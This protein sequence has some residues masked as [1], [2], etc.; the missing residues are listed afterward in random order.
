MDTQDNNFIMLPTVDF[1]F[2]E[3]MQ[4]PKVR[5]GFIAALLNMKPESIRKTILLPTILRRE[6]ENDK[7]GILD[8]RIQLEDGTQMDMEMQVRY[9]EYWD[10]RTLFY[11]SKMFTE[12][13]NAGDDYDALKKCIHISV[14][15]FNHYKDDRCYRTV[16]L[17]D[18]KTG[19]LYSDKIELQILELQKLAKDA[20][21]DEDII[22]WI[23]FFAGKSR[24]EFEK[25]AKNDEYLD[26][27][28]NELLKLSADERKRLEYNAREKALLDHNSFMSSAR[29]Q[30]LREGRREGQRE[31][32]QIYKKLTQGQSVQQ[33]AE[34]LNMSE[35]E[36]EEIIRTLE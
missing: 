4:N 1:C 26:E 25:M 5:Q 19:E 24:E 32:I 8:V 20:K 16:H 18:D 23:R 21:T 15:D 10:E 6:S 12:Q 22:R 2:K 36:I 3:L 27:A 28:Y 7:L 33:I 30:G 35:K 11:L 34:S 17:R 9:Y 13:I 14:L 31:G 29:R